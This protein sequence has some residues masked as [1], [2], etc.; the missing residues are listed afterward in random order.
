MFDTHPPFQIDGNFGAA[1]AIAEMLVQSDDTQ[2]MLLPALP[3]A[4]QDGRV[5]GLRVRG[6]VKVDIEWRGGKLL[7]AALT[8]IAPRKATVRYRERHVTARLAAGQTLHLDAHL[9]QV[10]A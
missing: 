5:T 8:S 4:W 10:P 6:G 3:S 2:V 9:R 7:N 1:A